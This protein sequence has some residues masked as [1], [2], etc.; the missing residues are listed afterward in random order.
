M[1]HASDTPSG[2][3]TW[4]VRFPAPAGSRLAP[5]ALDGNI[6]STYGF[7]RLVAADVVEDGAA[8]LLTFRAAGDTVADMRPAGPAEHVHT[9]GADEICACSS[10]RRCAVH[11]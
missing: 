8:A 6:G 11:P 4:T 7:G 1:E 10:G 5:G 2:E 3:G 9:Y